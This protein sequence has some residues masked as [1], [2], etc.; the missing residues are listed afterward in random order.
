[1]KDNKD[2]NSG[3][4]LVE[5]VI[6]MAVLSFLMTA[7]C[8][9]MG[10]SLSSY[11][12]NKADIELQ[13]S[14]MET[15]NQI[16]ENLMQANKVVVKGYQVSLGADIDFSSGSIKDNLIKKGGDTDPTIMEFTSFNKNQSIIA[17]ELVVYSAVEIDRVDILASD[18]ANSYT[19][20]DAGDGTFDVTVKSA[21]AE[22]TAPA[23]TFK[24]IPAAAGG[25]NTSDV[26]TAK[27]TVKTTYTFDGN[28]MYVKREYAYMTNRNDTVS[29]TDESLL[30][31]DTFAMADDGTY[32]GCVLNIN[33]DKKNIGLTL[34]FSD[35]G[36][37]YTSTG[38]VNVRNTKVFE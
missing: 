18:A 31:N 36:V 14:S 2:S 19:E 21:F 24:Y 11:K 10:I 1:M 30:F 26:Y 20:T 29:Y 27:D 22:S 3:F 15:Y 9:F 38:A 17:K 12:K 7:V 28:N 23:D 35:K 37:D 8:S 16:T 33:P 32:S 13:T 25:S 4:T 6:A 5:L 34:H